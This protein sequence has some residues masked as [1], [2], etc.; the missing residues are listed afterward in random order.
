MPDLLFAFGM[1]GQFLRGCRM[2]AE[3]VRE[4]RV[5]AVGPNVSRSPEQFPAMPAT[6]EIE[7]VNTRN[8]VFKLSLIST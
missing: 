6:R 4:G 7:S 8:L 2:F 5:R 3:T 1:T